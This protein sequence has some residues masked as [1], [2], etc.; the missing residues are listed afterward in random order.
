M[1]KIS[2]QQKWL[3]L[4]IISVSALVLAFVLLGRFMGGESDSPNQQI[5]SMELR[6]IDF[7]GYRLVAS[8]NSGNAG[9]KGWQAIPPGAVEKPQIA[10]IVSSWQQLLN[11]A[12]EFE[13]ND[14]YKFDSATSVLIFFEGSSQPSVVRV[15]EDM[16][17]Q[18]IYFYI[19]ATG[20][21]L[22]INR[23]P[24]LQFLP[25]LQT[26]NKRQSNS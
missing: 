9:T 13:N 22:E 19:I 10:K 24:Q 16:D 21:K 18:K 2:K 11:S 8:S 4:I 17:E 26:S 25:T 15:S 6:E 20:Q 3:N 1:V 14:S 23:S 7:G 12:F 5:D